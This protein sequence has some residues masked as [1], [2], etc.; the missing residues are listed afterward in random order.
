[1]RIQITTG[2]RGVETNEIYWPP[3]SLQDVDEALGQ[4]LID[5]GQAVLVPPVA[6]EPA[7]V[8]PRK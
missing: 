7:A 6:I 5:N 8:K 3:E 4:R 1:M 2:F